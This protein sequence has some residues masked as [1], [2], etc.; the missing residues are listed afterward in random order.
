MFIIFIF[1]AV[2]LVGQTCGQTECQAANCPSHAYPLRC[3]KDGVPR[4]NTCKNWKEFQDCSRQ[5][6]YHV[7]AP[8]D[9]MHSCLKKCIA[10]AGSNIPFNSLYMLAAT[11]LVINLR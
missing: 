3:C 9:D 10:S 8:S 1:V 11:L 2:V 7:I 6:C 4:G 5:K